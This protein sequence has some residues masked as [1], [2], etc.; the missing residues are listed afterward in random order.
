MLILHVCSKKTGKRIISGTII[1]WVVV[2][3]VIIIIIIGE[4][5]NNKNNNP[6]TILITVKNTPVSS[7]PAITLKNST[8]PM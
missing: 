3:N 7:P 4:D 8:L 2:I 5:Y 6:K 1:S